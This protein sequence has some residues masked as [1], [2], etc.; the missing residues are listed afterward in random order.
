MAAL[1]KDISG[2]EEREEEGEGKER[3]LELN[4]CLGGLFGHEAW[5]S[6]QLCCVHHCVIV[7]GWYLSCAFSGKW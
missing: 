5:L 4:I 6:D 3:I 2:R 1:K 7:D